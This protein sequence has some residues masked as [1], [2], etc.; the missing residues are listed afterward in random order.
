MARPMRLRGCLAIAVCVLAIFPWTAGVARADVA[1]SRLP[2]APA[3]VASSAIA[4]PA[5]IPRPTPDGGVDPLLSAAVVVVAVVG[6]FSFIALTRIASKSKA[7]NAI[8][9]EEPAPHD[10]AEPI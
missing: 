3:T 5:P 6:T 1:A 8:D 9:A 10:H 7:S 2:S 4:T